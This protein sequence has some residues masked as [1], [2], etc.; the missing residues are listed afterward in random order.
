MSKFEEAVKRTGPM[1]ESCYS[2]I[3]TVRESGMQSYEEMSEILVLGVRALEREMWDLA[4][5]E[6][7][8]ARSPEN[9]SPESRS[10]ENK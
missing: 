3:Q 4:H 9:R 7:E 10:P 5:A 8:K 1:L 6:L 2:A